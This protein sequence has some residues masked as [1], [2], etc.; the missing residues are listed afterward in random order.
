MVIEKYH[1]HLGL[2]KM[3]VMFAEMFFVRSKAT[4][5][6]VFAPLSRNK[7]PPCALTGTCTVQVL[8]AIGDQTWIEMHFT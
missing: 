4:R 7:V 6:L 1:F 5:R 3:F 8:D 2:H